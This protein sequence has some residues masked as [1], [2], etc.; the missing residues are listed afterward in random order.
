ETRGI[1]V[2]VED[3]R[4]ALRL[5]ACEHALENGLA[6]DAN[7][8][9]VAAAHAPRQSAGEHEAQRR[10]FGGCPRHGR[11]A[12]VFRGRWHSRRGCPAAQT[13]RSLRKLDC[14]PGM[15]TG[16]VVRMISIIV[17]RGLAPVLGA[18]LLDVVEVL[19]EHDA[20]LA[21]EGD[22]PLA[23]RATD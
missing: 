6:G 15:T 2:G 17:H 21:C 4:R 8:R 16:D 1:A 22:E 5:E 20:L 14:A 12:N 23:A 13:L 9:L 18:L 7:T 3:D 19:I 11:V 10:C